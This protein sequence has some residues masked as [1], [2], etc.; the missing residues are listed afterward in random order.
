MFDVQC[1]VM[2]NT[3]IPCGIL[4]CSS[5]RLSLHGT[6]WFSFCAGG[7]MSVIS[8]PNPMLHMDVTDAS[9]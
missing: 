5:Y 8:Q 9:T 1:V 3:D 7:S 4:T 2:C 6:C